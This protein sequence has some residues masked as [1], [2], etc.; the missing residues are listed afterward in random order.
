MTDRPT[1]LRAALRAHPDGLTVRQLA[2]VTGMRGAAARRWAD[3]MPDV[4]V[5]RWVLPT[6]AHAG[7][8]AAVYVVFDGVAPPDCP[9]P[10]KG[11]VKK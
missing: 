5:D 8:S 2:D 7:R 4:C 11:R 1:L 10:V 9:P 6:T 3:K